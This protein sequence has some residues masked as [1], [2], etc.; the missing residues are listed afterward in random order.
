[1]PEI[2]YNDVGPALEREKSAWGTGIA[3]A[4]CLICGE[5]ALVATAFRQVLDALLP[6]GQ[7]ALQHEPFDGDDASLYDVL[8]R[9]NTFSL[10]GGVR[11]VSLKNARIFDS[12][13]DPAAFGEAAATAWGDK[14]VKKAAGYFMRYLATAGLTLDEAVADGVA[15][16][17]KLPSAAGGDS[18]WAAKLAAHCRE[19]N[20]KLP[21]I[22]DE[23]ETL[24]AAIARGY[25]RDHYLLLTCDLADKRRK[26]YKELKEKALIIDCS[27][28]KGD[29]KADRA[30]QE[31]VL[32][33]RMGGL[34]EKAGKTMDPAAFQRMQGLIGFDL[35]TFENGVAKLV[36]YTGERATIT[37]G[38]V[39]A[40]LTRTRKDPMYELNNAVCER[41]VERALVLARSLLED[42]DTHALM[43]LS[44]LINQVRRLLLARAFM[45]SPQG[46]A[47]RQGM[48]FNQFK[49]GVVPAIS[50]FDRELVEMTAEWKTRLQSKGSEAGTK[51]DRK[52]A[53]KKAARKKT[54]RGG[55]DLLLA[56]SP[57][58]YPL[59]LLLQRAGRF[60][61]SELTVAMETLSESDRM[62]KS[63][64]RDPGLIL[65]RAL[66]SICLPSTEKRGDA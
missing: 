10:T 61:D 29:R 59:Y 4:T 53:G 14:K 28:P 7:Q 47:W 22:R 18:G 19:K 45:Q 57:S 2:R 27:V 40:V 54:A 23:G 21:V 62:L 36:S 51:G 46:G 13:Q 39:D 20:M 11:V 31:T 52:R 12:G 8:E 15:G 9:V 50:D 49:S 63:S 17:G 43:V 5:E 44:M 56:K 24:I 33:E 35:R 66:L 34:L 37:A 16:S 25:P 48:T 6:A 32:R 3:A 26:R 1:M 38:D 30:V 55:S 41:R 42:K 64:P 65:E 60:T 58:P